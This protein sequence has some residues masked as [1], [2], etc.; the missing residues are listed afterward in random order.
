YNLPA[1]QFE[2]EITETTLISNFSD[3]LAMMHRLKALGFR[4]AI[5]DFG[6][7]YSSL[8]YLK[9]MPVDVIKIDKSFVLGMLDSPQD[10]QIVLSTIAMVHKLGL[11]VVAEG[12]ESFAMAELL[13]QHQCNFA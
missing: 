6:A 7:G 4:F 2:L 12:V 8:N 3:T 1:H 5:D 9:R 11:H 13:Q 10:C